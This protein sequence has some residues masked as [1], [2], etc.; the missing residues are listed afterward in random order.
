MGKRQPFW[1]WRCHMKS[2]DQREGKDYPESH[3]ASI[4]KDMDESKRAPWKAKAGKG[5]SASIPTGFRHDPPQRPQVVSTIEQQESEAQIRRHQI[6][7]LIKEMVE[8]T[9][10]PELLRRKFVAGA[11]NVLV[12]TTEGEF[13]PVELALLP[14]TL[15]AGIGGEY[16]HFLNPG[17]VPV[18]YMAKAKSHV[19][20]THKIPLEGYPGAVDLTRPEA[21]E[22]LMTEITIFLN[23]CKVVFGETTKYVIFCHTDMIDQF[24]KS[25]EFIA[26]KSQCQEVMS[27]FEDD[28]I[29][30]GDMA[31]LLLFMYQKVGV[32][33]VLPLCEDALNKIMF[34]YCPGSCSFHDEQ[35][36]NYC[37]LGSV[38]RLWY[39]FSDAVLPSFGITPIPYQHLPVSDTSGIRIIPGGPTETESKPGSRKSTGKSI[40]SSIFGDNYNWGSSSS[41][42]SGF[43]SVSNP[44][45]D[46]RLKEFDQPSTS[47]LRKSDPRRPPGGIGRGIRP[48]H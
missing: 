38:R 30:V 24:H 12:R 19:D 29:L 16:H 36:N 1:L 35:D 26:K 45:Q 8:K 18:G 25:L 13:L 41:M 34:D 23:D 47:G 27:L 3:Y 5:G 37:A 39:K 20:S 28:R 33:T 14:Y 15:D 10:I 40:A 17:G 43:S 6:S 46:P 42:A 32:P 48:N 31:E 7:A 9:P 22:N 4:W 2:R 11:T 21:C 44:R